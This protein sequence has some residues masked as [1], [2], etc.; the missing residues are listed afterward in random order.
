MCPYCGEGFELIKELHAH[1]TFKH[2]IFVLIVEKLFK[3]LDDHTSSE[4]EKVVHIVA[5]DLN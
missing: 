4:H 3:E 1:T 5:K 2:E